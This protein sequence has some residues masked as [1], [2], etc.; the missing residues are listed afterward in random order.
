M[1]I[2]KQGNKQPDLA[3]RCQRCGCEFIC[4]RGE[5][6]ESYYTIERIIYVHGCPCCGDTCYRYEYN[7][8]YERI[9]FR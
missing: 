2:L 7:K 1:K 6:S 8:K 5:I 3:F 4:E 9:S